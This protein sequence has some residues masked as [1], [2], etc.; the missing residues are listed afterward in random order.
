MSE[1]IVKIDFFTP[2]TLPPRL[3]EEAGIQK[4]GPGLI[5]V[6]TKI[7]SPVSYEFTTIGTKPDD[8]Q[9]FMRDLAREDG[10]D[11]G[12]AIRNAFSEE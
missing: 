9:K 11:L 3:R 1:K 8:I 12:I 6:K 7:G 4:L 5:V 10:V 2:K